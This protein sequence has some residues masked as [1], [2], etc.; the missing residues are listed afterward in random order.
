MRTWNIGN[1]TVRNPARIVGALRVFADGF[2]GAEWTPAAEESFYAALRNAKVCTQTK[3]V[4]A[5]TSA[6]QS[7]RKW[8]SAFKQLGFATVGRG[9]GLVALTPVGEALLEPDADVSDIFLRQ[10]LKQHVPSAVDESG[11]DFDVYPLRLTL[12][13]IERLRQLGLAAPT[14]EEVSL[15]LIT[16]VRDSDEELAVQNIVA[17][18]RERDLLK[19]SVAKVDFFRNTLLRTAA[20]LYADE[21]A[22]KRECLVKLHTEALRSPV[23]LGSSDAE[24]LLRAVVGSGKGHRTQKALR[25]KQS[26]SDALSHGVPLEDL[27]DMVSAQHFATRARTLWDYADTTARY[28]AMTGLFVLA[29]SRLAIKDSMEPLAVVL[30]ELPYPSY[31]AATY[32]AS[33]Y[34]P[35]EPSLPTDDA[36][37]IAEMAESLLV[38]RGQLA[39]SLG[40]PVPAARSISTE[41]RALRREM[42][43]LEF[44]VNELREE[45]FYRQQA[46]M[47][48]EIDDFF[49]EIKNRTLFGGMAYLPAYYEWNVWRVFLAVNQILND[50]PST[51][52][53]KL[54]DKM[55]PMHHAAAGLPDMLFEYKDCVLVV[56]ATLSTGENQW[57]QEG[58]SV[59]KHVKDVLVKNPGRE[60]IGLFVAPRIDANTAVTFRNYPLLIDH[61]EHRMDIVPLTTEQLRVLLKWFD[62]HGLDSAELVAL[63]RE[64]LG[65]RDEVRTGVA[66]LEKIEARIKTMRVSTEP[67][68]AGSPS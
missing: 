65:L 3:D 18:R 52:G 2:V 1:T 57:S 31:D 33:F 8:A 38:T 54:N 16:T 23:Y 44:E 37:F 51:R 32:I 30:A 60:V 45:Q 48:E 42:S 41:P 67:T 63:L 10:L 50:L 61:Q 11:R 15:F 46:E 28:F 35:N 17:Y 25:L 6:G 47:A 9:A 39:L 49:D 29:G 36:A 68:L 24:E 4:I 27:W 26:L 43:A 19:G 21:V 58:Q 55:Y 12:K 62:G 5:E 40:R 22:E 66:W 53:F 64:Y 20:E 34:E 59:P 14:R 7:G 13:V 56:E